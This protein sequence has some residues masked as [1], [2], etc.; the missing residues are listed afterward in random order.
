MSRPH[1][2]HRLSVGPFCF[3]PL[4]QPLA[5]GELVPLGPHFVNFRPEIL[6]FGVLFHF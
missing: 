3:P 2:S 1:A 4:D 6:L 5:K